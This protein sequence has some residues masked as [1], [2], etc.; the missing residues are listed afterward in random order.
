MTKSEVAALAALDDVESWLKANMPADPPLE[1]L[2]ANFVR[3]MDAQGR[4]QGLSDEA[5]TAYRLAN[6]LSMSVD[7]L[8]RYWKKYRVQ[9]GG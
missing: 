4:A 2:K 6:P 9:P 3:A 5:I 7:G 1:E 8:V